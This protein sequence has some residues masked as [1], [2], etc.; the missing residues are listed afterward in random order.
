VASDPPT[1]KYAATGTC[2]RSRLATREMV[3]RLEHESPEFEWHVG[4]SDQYRDY[5]LRGERADGVRVRIEPEDES[6]E[7]YLGV[8][9][10]GMKVFP[11]EPWRI[12]TARRI[13]ERMLPVV[14]GIPKR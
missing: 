4:D 7:Y 6:D 12:E 14:E 10:A 8:Y 9:F 11:D 5:Y 13:Q 3:G 2:F 1:G